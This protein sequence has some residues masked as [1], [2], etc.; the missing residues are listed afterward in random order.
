[1]PGWEAAAALLDPEAL[2]QA[3]KLSQIGTK[4]KMVKYALRE[5]SLGHLQAPT[6]CLSQSTG[7]P[8]PHTWLMVGYR[9]VRLVRS[10][11]LWSRVPRIRGQACMSAA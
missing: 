1:M 7:L 11:G 2:L 9:K 10:R 6:T 4:P 8:R 5:E 3:I